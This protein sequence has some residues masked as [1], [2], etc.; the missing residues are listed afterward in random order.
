ME[1]DASKFALKYEDRNPNEGFVLHTAY[2]NVHSE[3]EPKFE[4]VWPSS[5]RGV[6]SRPLAPRLDSLSGKRIAFLWDYLFR[7]DEL[8]P[9]LEAELGRR[10]PGVEF[11][12]YEVFGN[13]HGPEEAQLVGEIPSVIAARG[14]DAVVSGV[15]C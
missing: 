4:V 3:N 13:L 12:G 11:V 6:Q 5:P 8:F 9:V 15:G 10:F 1:S 14:V 2:M 7:G